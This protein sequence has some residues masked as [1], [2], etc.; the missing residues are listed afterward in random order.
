MLHFIGGSRKCLVRKMDK[1]KRNGCGLIA[2][3]ELGVKA[4]ILCSSAGAPSP[5]THACPDPFF[6][7][8][9][10][11]SGTVFSTDSGPSKHLSTDFGF[12]RR[13]QTAA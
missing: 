3:L 9:L 13:S 4:V 7:C 2:G 11:A 10:K 8:V 12:T 5:Q 6:F 1:L